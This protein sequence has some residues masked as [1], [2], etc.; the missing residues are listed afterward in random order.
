M[1]GRRREVI[2]WYVVAPDAA[3]AR[4]AVWN[5]PQD[6]FLHPSPARGRARELRRC[7][8]PRCRVWAI[9][10]VTSARD[11]RTLAD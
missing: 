5:R 7:R 8:D 9:D 1:R 2:T 3:G 10:V 11:I 6:R 4:Y